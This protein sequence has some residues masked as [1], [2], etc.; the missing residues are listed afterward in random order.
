MGWFG[1]PGESGTHE[2]IDRTVM[3]GYTCDNGDVV[4]FTDCKLVGFNHHWFVYRINDEPKAICLTLIQR[5]RE[6]E[7]RDCEWLYKPMD[8]TCGP[9]E[10]D[11]PLALLNLVPEPDNDYARDW[12]KSVRKY[13]AQK[14]A[15]NVNAIVGAR[16][17]LH[18]GRLGTIVEKR[19]RTIIGRLDEGGRYRIPRGM[20]ARTFKQEG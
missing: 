7:E 2:Q 4:T 5:Y 15:V 11:C 8:E 18:G 14:Q 6:S 1:T 12:R 13:H 17:E 10:V 16:F 20:I 3:R 9:N 19:G